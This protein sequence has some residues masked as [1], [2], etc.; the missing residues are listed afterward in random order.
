MIEVQLT[1]YDVEGREVCFVVAMATRL[2]AAKY[3]ASIGMRARLANNPAL[4]AK[5]RKYVVEVL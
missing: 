4:A 3:A 1:A 5:A 2:P